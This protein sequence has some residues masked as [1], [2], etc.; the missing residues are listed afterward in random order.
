MITDPPELDGVKDPADRLR[1]AIVVAV[2]RAPT[3]HEWSDVANRPTAPVAGGGTGRAGRPMFLAAAA[4]VVLGVVGIL[5]GVTRSE[6]QIV[7]TDDPPATTQPDSPADA[8]ETV[9]EP[10]PTLPE[11]LTLA[12]SVT[13]EGS[14]PQSPVRLGETIVFGQQNLPGV[15]AVDARSGDVLWSFTLADPDPNTAI[16]GVHVVEDRVL[17][18]WSDSTVTHMVTALDASGVELWTVNA[19]YIS[20]AVIGGSVK[21]GVPGLDLIDADGSVRRSIGRTDGIGV[22][23]DQFVGEDEEGFSWYGLPGFDRIAGPTPILLGADYSAVVG[24]HIV[25]LD[26]MLL[27]FL[28]QSGAVLSKL[29]IDHPA[30]IRLVSGERPGVVVIDPRMSEDGTTT[31]Y[32][33]VDDTITEVWTRSGQFVELAELD[34]RTF[35]VQTEA[36]EGATSDT[37]QSVID[38][39]TGSVIVSNDLYDTDGASNGFVFV[40]LDNGSNDVQTVAYDDGGQEMWRLQLDGRERAEIVDHGVLVAVGGARGPDIELTFFE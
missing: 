17:I 21:D 37:R 11:E 9:G 31:F 20:G 40:Q 26:G 2:T 13:I 22:G 32:E 5:V 34:G 24:D 8:D 15:R 35:V 29:E 18:A 39:T 10:L 30:T 36:V 12:W 16:F 28:D 4:A 38:V 23:D 3:A 7:R 1:D 19:V 6:T 14:Y 25:T 27:R 33:L